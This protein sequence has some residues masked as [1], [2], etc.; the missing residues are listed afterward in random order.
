MDIKKSDLNWIFRES[1]KKPKK[2]DKV[3]VRLSSTN[4][5]EDVV[6]IAKTKWGFKV[7]EY[8]V[9]KA[10]YINYFEQLATR[11][12][13]FSKVHIFKVPNFKRVYPDKNGNIKQSK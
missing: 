2:G 5:W 9:P 8:S 3:W 12:P 11:D 1:K 6:F 4:R 13:Y 7:Y 10:E